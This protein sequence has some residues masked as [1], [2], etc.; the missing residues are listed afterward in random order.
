MKKLEDSVKPVVY[1]TMTPNM[2]EL[3]N[4]KSYYNTQLISNGQLAM[5]II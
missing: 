5:H 3:S 2:T 1:P 4:I